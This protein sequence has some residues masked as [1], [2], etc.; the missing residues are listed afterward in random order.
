MRV[1][2]AVPVPKTPSTLLPV[3][4]RIFCQAFTSSPR[5]PTLSVCIGGLTLGGKPLRGA[6]YHGRAQQAQQHDCHFPAGNHLPPR[7][8]ATG[9][10][11][12]C[13][14][15]FFRNLRSSVTSRAPGK[16]TS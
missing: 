1:A 7:F 15:F 9:E 3:M 14:N 11:V 2:F 5:E 16:S 8:L 6:H 13:E 4:P 10:M 12:T